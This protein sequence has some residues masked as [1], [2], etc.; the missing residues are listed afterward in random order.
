M[1][2]VKGVG[3]LV[4]TLKTEVARLKDQLAVADALASDKAAK[5]AQA[6]EA[7]SAL[8]Q[9]LEAGGLARHQAVV[10]AP[11]PEGRMKPVISFAL[12]FSFVVA[13]RQLASAIPAHLRV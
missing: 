8:A 1:A 4:E 5:T 13:I 12:F 10:A 3:G 2:D 6:I 9:R 7:F 11:S